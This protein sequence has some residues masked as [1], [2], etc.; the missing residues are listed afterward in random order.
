MKLTEETF[1][2][3]AL[4]KYDNVQCVTL[5]EFEEDLKRITWVKKL[6]YRYKNEEDLCERIILNHLIVLFNVFGDATVKMLF[7]RMERELW[8]YLV[9]FLIYLRRMPDHIP[10]HNLYSCDVELDQLIVERLRKL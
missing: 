7:F 2:Q 4:N 5:K 10:E 6:F 3:L 8:T 9:T 1:L